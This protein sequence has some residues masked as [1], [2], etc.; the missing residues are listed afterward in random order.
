MPAAP[1]IAKKLSAGSSPVAIGMELD[2]RAHIYANE[3]D[4]N[5]SHL[6]E[7]LCGGEWVRAGDGAEPEP[8]DAAIERRMGELNTRRKIRA[9]AVRAEGFVLSS[10]AQLDDATAV[11]FLKEGIGWMAER[12]GRENV[13]AA[14][15]HMDEDTPHAQFWIAPVI[16][17]ESTGYDRLSAKELFTPNRVD[18]KEKKVIEEG[19]LT[20][21][22]RDFWREVASRYGYSE[23][24]TVEQRMS[25]G[26]EYKSQAEYKAGKAL[27]AVEDE[28]GRKE[29]RSMELNTEIADKE[30]DLVE[31]DSAIEDRRI[32]LRDIGGQ[33]QQEQRRLESV[34][35]R[36]REKELEPA[37]E[38]LAESARTLYEARNDGEREEAL[39]GEVEGLRSRIRELEGANRAA[40]E[41]VAELDR[42]LPALRARRDRARERFGAVELRV[43]Q[44]M[45]GLR[46]IPN[47]V[48]A[49]AQGIARKLGKRTYNPN[50]LDYVARRATEAA[51]AY[52]RSRGWEGTPRRSHSRGR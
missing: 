52:N 44:A 34:R 35:Q 28:L 10:N 6:N 37:Q 7:Y 14:A 46:E 36:I 22:Q 30:G 24:F 45:R 16:H 13:L 17:D 15:I 29:R 40:R 31:L 48:S 41:R 51:R 38:T 33:I 32:E 26:R 50:S 42:G 2:R 3:V 47:T 1:L 23:P 27:R 25:D 5:R 21:L 20:K 18:R 19:T 39:A 43:K 49:W 4:P 8:L 12:Y 11:R 9:D